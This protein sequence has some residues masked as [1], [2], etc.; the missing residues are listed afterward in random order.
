MVCC[1]SVHT[2]LFW[3]SKEQ[4]EVL[5]NALVEEHAPHGPTEEHLVEEIA[6]VIWRKRRLRIAEA[7]S[8]RLAIRKYGSLEE[9]FDR[10]ELLPRVAAELELIDK[11]DLDAAR[12]DVWGQVF[13]CEKLEQLSRYEVHL[14]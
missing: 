1:R 3:E 6:G 12:E 5:L 14:V 4:Y 8:C 2:I 11:R 7:A 9:A 10:V 13:P